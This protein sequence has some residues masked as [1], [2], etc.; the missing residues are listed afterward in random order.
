MKTFLQEIA[1]KICNSSYGKDN[2]LDKIAI[3]F[4]NRR[5]AIYLRKILGEQNE[6]KAFFMPAI[7]G[8]NNLIE[9]LGRQKII[10]NEYLLFEL[11]E[12]HKE[13]E[14]D[15]RKYATFDE[16]IAFG[17]LM[18]KDF[19][20]LDLYCVDAKQIFSYLND[21]KHIE[22]W[23]IEDPNNLSEFQRR[24]LQFYES[25][26]EYYKRLKERLNKDG[27]AYSGMAYRNVAENIEEIIDNTPYEYIYFVGFN[28]LSESEKRI[29]KKYCDRG[30]GEL[31][32]DGDAYYYDDYDHEAGLFLRRQSETFPIKE[33]YAEHF[34]EGEIKINIVSC[35]EN[36]QQVKYAGQLIQELNVDNNT[37]EQTAV[38][39]ADEKMLVPM[40]NSLPDS[41]KSVNVTMGYPYSQSS[42]HALSL[43]LLDLHTHKKDG[44]YYHKDVL[45]ILSDPLLELSK[46]N[47]TASEEIQKEHI[48]YLSKEQIKKYTTSDQWEK[49]RAL[50][51][52]DSADANNWIAMAKEFGREL[53]D[54]K[55]I[56]HNAK[57]RESIG[58]WIELLQYLHELQKNHD[59]FIDNISL[60]K[61]IYDR[62]SQ[63]K[64]ISFYGEPLSGLQILGM[65]ETR[66]LDFKRIILL[67]ANEGIVPAGHKGNSLI[68]IGIKNIFHIPTYTEKDAVY[69][70]HFYCLLQRAEEIYLVYHTDSEGIGK[71]EASRYIAQ[72]RNELVP[73]YKNIRLEEHTLATQSQKQTTANNEI[74]K[75][76][77]IYGKIKSL[78]Q[79]GLSPSALNVY[80]NCPLQ[81]YYRYVLSIRDNDKDVEELDTSETGT[82]IHQ[83][84]QEIYE[85]DKGRGLQIET[86]EKGL[87][88]Y[89]TKINE[90]FNELPQT[91][92]NHLWKT[93]AIKQ[94][95]NIINYDLGLLKDHNNIE[96][97]A[98]E[99]KISV[100]KEINGMNIKLSG[101]IDRIDRYDGQTRIIDYKTGDVSEKLTYD[102]SKKITDKS[103]QVLF[104]AWLYTET[105]KIDEI[106]GAIYALRYKNLYKEITL[107]E[108]N[109]TTIS[110]ET[111]NN[112]YTNCVEKIITELLDRETPFK[113]SDKPDCKYCKMKEYCKKIE[114]NN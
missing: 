100:D 22:Q 3:V 45:S 9:I 15:N 33:K 73:R 8:M 14:G 39:L 28:A 48:P 97:I 68:P 35:S 52:D 114:N 29:A 47:V 2:K 51:A 55:Y 32:T 60:L 7:L 37:L 78:A 20:E 102:E 89:T 107:K 75:D 41:V 90:K 54:T 25:L 109:T 30:K 104:Y 65:L 6:R 46:A 74:A 21:T 1:E 77:A 108:G 111:L 27:E 86:L 80:R 105:S 17:D 70:N 103:F 18:I 61:K 36:I 95:A 5:P 59:N 71:G 42:V 91:G 12:I 83:I 50:F 57:E 96:I 43:K 66:N 4:N 84:L 98:L 113:A 58:C 79:K 67:S 34:G 88:N 16:F 106:Q 63:H 87:E 23:N 24:Y 38:V 44:K 64:S 13:I 81:Y 31:I 76:D 56:K 62:L 94:I 53:Y 101:T 92:R 99:E 10:E 85:Q 112:Y 93:I 82:I 110:Q 26:Y 19:S 11:F 69:A 49:I 40:L 72:I